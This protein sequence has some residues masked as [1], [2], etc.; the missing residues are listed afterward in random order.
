MEKIKLKTCIVKDAVY[1][2]ENA[3]SMRINVP[4]ILKAGNSIDGTNV[5]FE[6]LN[7]YE[8]NLTGVVTFSYIEESDECSGLDFSVN[9]E[10]YY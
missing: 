1:Y 5:Q 3:H 9:K 4:S 6:R 7:S 2:D 10:F 8:S